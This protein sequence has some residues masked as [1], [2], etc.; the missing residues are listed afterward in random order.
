MEI[1]EYVKKGYAVLVTGPPSSGKTRLAR[2]LAESRLFRSHFI[3]LIDYD[4][5]PVYRDILGDGWGAK[6]KFYFIDSADEVRLTHYRPGVY[7]AQT[8]TPRNLHPLPVV[9]VATRD[10]WINPREYDNVVHV[11]TLK[12]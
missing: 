8:L 7:V 10:G 3:P 12:L 6:G 2:I 11:I 9:V 4:H 5:Y 1:L